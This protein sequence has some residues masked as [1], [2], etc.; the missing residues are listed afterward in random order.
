MIT[1]REEFLIARDALITHLF[2]CRRVPV[3][4][5][6][7]ATGVDLGAWLRAAVPEYR[8]EYRAWRRIYQADRVA[9]GLG[10]NP[11]ARQ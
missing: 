1:L 5:I 2:E 7:K 4:T 3:G 8:R 9:T 11:W 6:D 10:P